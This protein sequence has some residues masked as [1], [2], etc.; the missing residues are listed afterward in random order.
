VEQLK[1]EFSH[2]IEIFHPFSCLEHPDS[3][4]GND[5]K[6]NEGYAGDT[7]GNP[8]SGTVTCCRHHFTW[9]I[10]TVFDMEFPGLLLDDKNKTVDAFLFLEE[11]YVVS[12]TIYKT[13]LSGLRLYHE[14]SKDDDEGSG[15]FGVTLDD[16]GVPPKQNNDGDENDFPE[17]GWEMKR[18]TSGPMVLTRD[19]WK[20]FQQNAIEY[21]TYDDYNWDW[22]IVHLMDKGLLPSRVLYPNEPQVMHIGVDGGLHGEKNGGTKWQ[23]YKVLHAPFPGP[24]HGTKFVGTNTTKQIGR[25]PKSTTQQLY[26]G[27]GHPADHEHCLKILQGLTK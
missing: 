21:C 12:P 15:Y 27:W 25:P 20:K 6:L 19:I 13:V 16:G 23:L 3:F 22:A 26:G 18:F 24:F 7:F 1:T 4:P 14:L 9:M 5:E 8:R 11:D 17:E 2:L 10:K